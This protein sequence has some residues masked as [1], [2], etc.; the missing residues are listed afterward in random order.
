MASEDNGKVAKNSAVFET[1]TETEHLG[2]F[3]IALPG[4]RNLGSPLNGSK[5]LVDLAVLAQF[6][7]LQ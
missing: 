4:P 5:N 2:L 1:F 6:K 7:A 3:P